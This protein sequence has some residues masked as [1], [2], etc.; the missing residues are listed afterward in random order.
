MNAKHTPGPWTV[1]EYEDE[2]YIVDRDGHSAQGITSVRLSGAGMNYSE[3][4]ANAHLVAASPDLLEALEELSD[5]MQGVIDGD[6][7]PDCLTLQPAR[8]AIA[9]AEG[10][11]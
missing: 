6:Y 11:K 3:A 9:K 4:L 5:L 8:A 1:A 7:K 2:A 10:L